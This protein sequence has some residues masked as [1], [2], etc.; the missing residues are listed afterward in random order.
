MLSQHHYGNQHCSFCPQGS[1][2]R[3]KTNT[4]AYSWTIMVTNI[5]PHGSRLRSK[6]NTVAYSQIIMETNNMVVEMVDSK[7]VADVVKA[8]VIHN[9]NI[10]PII[11]VVSV[12]V[13]KWC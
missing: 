1:R 11:V 13:V 10:V 2:L 12:Y 6:T 9:T 7:M 4:V 3:P 8:T 5:C